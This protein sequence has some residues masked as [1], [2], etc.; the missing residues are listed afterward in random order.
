MVIIRFFTMRRV[1]VHLL[2]VS[3]RLKIILKHSQLEYNR[4][5][6][7]NQHPEPNIPN[8]GLGNVLAIILSRAFSLRI[9]SLL[10]TSNI[11]K[12]KFV[13]PIETLKYQVM[14]S[15]EKR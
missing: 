11:M 13:H 2:G 4:S 14:Y 5:N 10:T 6:L 12:N 9:R 3:E 8:R 7:S 1:K 15:I